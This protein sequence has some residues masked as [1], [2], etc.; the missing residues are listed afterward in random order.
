MHSHFG[1]LGD[2]E[3]TKYAAKFYKRE[4]H[5]ACY[6]VDECSMLDAALWDI[7]HEIRRMFPDII[8]VC[9]F[10]QNQ[11]PPVP[12]RPEAKVAFGARGESTYFDTHYIK[13]E[14]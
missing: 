5:P 9:V 14:I 4:S 7:V 11:C 12:P 10:D 8:F 3:A 6:I 1:V 2:D 13:N